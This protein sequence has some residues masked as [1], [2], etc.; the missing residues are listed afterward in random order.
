MSCSLLGTLTT[1]DFGGGSFFQSFPALKRV[2]SLKNSSRRIQTDFVPQVDGLY[3][4]FV[5]CLLLSGLSNLELSPGFISLKSLDIPR[6]KYNYMMSKRSSQRA[7]QDF[8]WG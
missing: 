2:E 8:K 7:F 1:S 4:L 5:S 3:V 6:K